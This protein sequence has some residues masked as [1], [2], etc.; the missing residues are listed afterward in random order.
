MNAPLPNMPWIK[1]YHPMLPSLTCQRK[2]EQTPCLTFPVPFCS[3]H[4]Y[5]V[6]SMLLH[7]SKNPIIFFP[8]D[9]FC[10]VIFKFIQYQEDRRRRGPKYTILLAYH[11]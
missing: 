3:T 2:S 4:L 8:S 5:L 9:F 11:Q 10:V 7:P 6:F 1:N